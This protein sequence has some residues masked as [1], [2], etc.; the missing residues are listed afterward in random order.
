MAVAQLCCSFPFSLPLKG[1]GDEKRGTGFKI[2]GLSGDT[3]K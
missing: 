2:R 3:V 1:K